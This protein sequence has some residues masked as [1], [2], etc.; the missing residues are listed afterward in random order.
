MRILMLHQHFRLP[1]EGGGIR[2]YYLAKALV[3]AG[4]EIDIITAHNKPTYHCHQTE[5]F[6]VHYL[7]VYYD[8]ALH[9]TGRSLAFVKFWWQAAKKAISLPRP[10]LCYAITTPLSVAA[11]SLFLK[12]FK[13]LPYIL[14]VGDLWPEAPIQMGV[15]RNRIFKK[16]LY[17]LE[18]RVYKEAEAV[19]P[20]SV[21]IERYIKARIPGIDTTVITNFADCS[22]FY[23]VDKQ[24]LPHITGLPQNSFTICYT[25]AFGK[26]NHLQ[27]ILDCAHACQAQHLWQVQFILMGQGAE[28]PLIEQLVQSRELKNVH[29]L[30]HAGKEEVRLVLNASD[31]AFVSFLDI[32]VLSTGCPNKYFDALA[33]GKL[34]IINMK[35]W[36]REEIENHQCGFYTDP[37][38]AHAFPAQLTPFLAN[39]LLLTTFQAN[40]R[41]LAE[42]AYS[43]NRQ[44]NLFKELIHKVASRLHIH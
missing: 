22:F 16:S 14:E 5:G 37:K 32:P 39:K 40:A 19:V 42:K 43:T 21:D 44:L 1:S 18:K 13:K 7:P 12:R 26:A 11:L 34:V 33:A 3:D 31:A 6:R 4:H 35:G 8:N 10:D 41:Q 20:Y 24:P 25:G 29:I 28:K 9:F 15:V 2:T 30:P 38:E 17:Y 36:I 27:Y 23:P